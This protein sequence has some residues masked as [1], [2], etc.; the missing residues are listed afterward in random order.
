MCHMPIHQSCLRLD[1]SSSDCITARSGLRLCLLL[2][3]LFFLL[4]GSVN[5]AHLSNP[6]YEFNVVTR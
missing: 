3:L 2:M 6:M 4:S 5:A 1:V